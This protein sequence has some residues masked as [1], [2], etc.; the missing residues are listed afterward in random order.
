LAGDSSTGVWNTKE[1]WPMMLSTARL[2]KCLPDLGDEPLDWLPVDI[3]ATAFLEIAELGEGEDRKDDM[4]VFHV[5]NP[6]QQPTW[7]Q[8][9]QWRKEKEDFEIVEPREWTKRLEECEGSEHSAMKLLGL[10]K[11]AYGNGGRV[12]SK[13]PMFSIEETRKEVG[14]LR[15]VRPLDEAYVGRVWDWIQANV[16]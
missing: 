6:H 10:W 1:A 16:R 9:L 3:A 13:R 2:I 12:A 4:P 14:A 5:L 7:T 8:M 11:D 15:D